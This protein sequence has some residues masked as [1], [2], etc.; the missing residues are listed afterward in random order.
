M[1]NTEPKA[2]PSTCRNTPC[3]FR[4]PPSPLWPWLSECFFLSPWLCPWL[5]WL[6]LSE[7][8]WPGD[9]VQMKLAWFNRECRMKQVYF[10]G[11]ETC[12]NF[13]SKVTPRRRLIWN[14][15]TQYRTISV[16]LSALIT[17]HCVL[18]FQAIH[19]RVFRYLR[20]ASPYRDVMEQTIWP[21]LFISCDFLNDKLFTLCTYDPNNEVTKVRLF[22]I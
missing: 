12:F 2:S 15:K 17:W 1:M 20:A 5:S 10:M 19:L 3:M 22:N 6:P 18:L 14:N 16:K 8:F 21:P 4:C 9:K 7:C 13:I 11:F